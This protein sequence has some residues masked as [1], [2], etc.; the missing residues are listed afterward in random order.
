MRFLAHRRRVLDARSKNCFRP[1]AHQALGAFLSVYRLESSR[2][3]TFLILQRSENL[4]V[5]SALLPIYRRLDLWQSKA[6]N[7]SRR[8]RSSCDDLAGARD[9]L[10]PLKE[11]VRLSDS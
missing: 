11:E 9:I 5:L 1:G 3:R 2:A 10:E 6:H 7:S 4:I 8:V